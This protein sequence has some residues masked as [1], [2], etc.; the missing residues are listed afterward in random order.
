MEEADSREWFRPILAEYNSQINWFNSLITDPK[1]LGYFRSKTKEERFREF[2][3]TIEKTAAFLDFL[4][5]PQ[6]EYAS[7]HIAGTGGKGSVTTMIGAILQAAGFKTGVHTNPYLQVPNEEWIIEGRMIAPS[8]LSLAISNLRPSYKALVAAHPNQHPSYVITQVALTHQLF[9]EERVDFGVIETGMGG[10]YDPSNVLSPEISVITNVDFDH[11]EALGPNLTDIASHKAG[12]IKPG[13]PVVTAA[14]QD[15]VL[16]VIK[17]EAQKSNAPLFLLGKDFS[18]E[19]VSAD[20]NGMVLDIA[21]PYGSYKGI[22]LSLPGLFQRENAALAVAAC[23]VLVHHKGF[24][25]DE[26]TINQALSNLRFSGR[27]ER[28]QEKPM[29]ILDGAHNPQKMEALAGSLVKLYPD[30][31]FIIII[32]MLATKEVKQSLKRLP[33]Q[34]KKVIAAEPHLVGKPS[35]PNQQMEAI[36][37]EVKP[38]VKTAAC[39]TVLEALNL[40]LKEAEDDEVILITGSLYMLGEVREYWFPKDDILVEAEINF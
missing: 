17:V 20:Q 10:R 8:R 22:Q 1:G 5:N 12:I 21:T 24:V 2:E 3:E 26:E 39:N 14:T 33:L 27:M 25:L 29:V 28:I 23:D 7:I 40:A 30:K 35:I 9:A 11:V 37:R 34:A 13:K 6:N 19:M 36:I 4:D 38:E 31:K 18:Y 32:G 16:G 15:E